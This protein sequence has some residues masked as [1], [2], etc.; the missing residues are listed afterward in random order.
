MPQDK[1]VV[2]GARENNLK[3]ITVEIPRDKLV[4]I[5]G[6]S[7]SGKSSLAFDTIYAE[8]Q[9]RYVES[10][11]AYARQFLGQ[12]DKPD[13]DHIEGL[14]PAVS[15][16][17]KSASKNPRSTVGTVTE[18]YDYLRIL[19]ARVGTPYCINGHGPIERQSTDQIVDVAK[20]LPEGTKMQ[21]LAP[22]IRGRKGEYKSVLQDINKAGYVRVR[23]DG[24][25]YEVTDDIPMDR[26][27]QHTIEVIVDRVVVKEGIERRLTD[28]I[29]AALKMGNGLITLSIQAPN[30]AELPEIVRNLMAQQ[31]SVDEEAGVST[32]GYTDVLFSE[33]Y[34]CPV[35]G[36]SL[37]E[38]EPRLFSFNSPYGACPECTGLGTKTEFDPDLVA[39]DH[40][41]SLRNGAILPFIYKSGEVKDWWPEMLDAVGRVVGFDAK[42]P[43]NEIPPE[44]MEAVWNGLPEPITVVMKY[45]RGERSF[46]TKWDG[47]LMALRKRFEQTE[48]E[49]VKNDLGQYMATKPC[50]VCLGRRLKPEA[51]SVKLDGTDMSQVTRMSI[52]DANV[53]FNSLSS[54]LSKRQ[55]AIGERAVKE[56]MERLRFLVDVGLSYLTL[57]RNAR[58]LAGG[59]AQRI[60]LA[61]QIGSGLM[62]CL[63]IL[64]EP[65]IGLHQ[66]DNRKLI[67]TLNRLRDIGNTVLVVEHDEETML[68]ADHLIELGPG[69]GEHGGVIVAQGTVEEFL[70]SDALTAQ[71]LNGTRQIEIP[72]TR[73]IAGSSAPQA[74]A[75]LV[76]LKLKKGQKAPE[77]LAE[78]Q[79]ISIRNARGHNLKNVNVD[80]PVGTFCCVTGVSGS[81]KS[82]LIQ[83]TL[84]P[85]LMFDVYG[86]RTVWEPHDTVEG[87]SFFDKVIDIDQSPIGRTPRSNPA[88]YTGTFDMIRDLFTLTQ[89]AKIRGYKTGRFSFNV[90]GGRC[91]ACKGDGVLKIEMVFLPDVYVPCEVCKGKRYNRETLEVKYKGKNIADVL[92]MTIDDA[93]DFFKPIPKIYRKL[94]TLQEVGLGYIRMG[95]PAT[96]LSGG[97]AQRIKLAA[98]LS[99]RATGRTMYILDEPTTGLHFEDVNRLLK[100]LHR[101]VDQGNTVL[102]IEHNLDVIK[103]ADYLIDM[104]PEGGTG[105]GMV[106]GYG[107][108]EQ[109]ASMPKSYTGK[110][111][112]DIFKKAKHPY[113]EAPQFA[114]VAETRKT[115]LRK[116]KAPVAG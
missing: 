24:V 33:S 87:I 21:I 38:L 13:V 68:A 97:E 95:Q 103:T 47:V 48:S 96:T 61:T 2:V 90:K 77:I 109:I 92:A 78:S 105:G 82:T 5:T 102:V 37:P 86:T 1:I 27:K 75:P 41:K 36:Y 115:T 112:A 43:I 93:C 81:G 108:P 51:L 74:T 70:R 32:D 9:R 54:R 49:W 6:L 73:R 40:S 16:D 15:I 28:S 80:I 79:W 67:E 14:S 45:S 69:A 50:P 100:V 55:M 76:P 42:L 18:I 17:Q 106:V 19:Y 7:G 104:G 39:P 114:M 56:V 35:C 98:E 53:F 66:R 64:D 26:Y 88:T 10:L 63:Y 34:S 83:D 57:D 65:S 94:E 30:E 11:S 99:K 111:L 62:G 72:K 84:F 8:G 46:K 101:L 22:V 107:T 31:K 89:D 110:Y 3:N 29:E 59:E 4:V 25:M 52:E 85:R 58:T 113:K 60:R 23:V 91:E 44:K 12:M 116:K 71:Y 20:A